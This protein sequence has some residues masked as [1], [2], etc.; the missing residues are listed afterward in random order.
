LKVLTRHFFTETKGK[1]RKTSVS[2]CG[3]LAEIRTQYLQNGSL[4]LYNCVKFF[5]SV[6]QSELDYLIRKVMEKTSFYD[7][8]KVLKKARQFIHAE[9]ISKIKILTESIETSMSLLVTVGAL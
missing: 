2:L 3:K 1:V 9:D 4:E 7:R 5:V 6:S 8:S